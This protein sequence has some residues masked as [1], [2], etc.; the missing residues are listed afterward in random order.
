MYFVSIN[1]I[2]YK[3]RKNGKASGGDSCTEGQGNR[4]EQNNSHNRYD[5]CYLMFDKS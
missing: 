3:K 5:S 2:G 4:T 1:A